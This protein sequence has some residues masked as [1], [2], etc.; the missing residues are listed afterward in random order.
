MNDILKMLK[1]SE[2]YN[3]NGEESKS[4]E[5]KEIPVSKAEESKE[6]FVS[7]MVPELDPG[8]SLYKRIMARLRRR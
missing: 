3:G 2:S 6:E 8:K 4:V 5:D 7:S 1:E